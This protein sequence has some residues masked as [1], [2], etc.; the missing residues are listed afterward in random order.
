MTSNKLKYHIRRNH[1]PVEHE[2]H[3][4]LV[5]KKDCKTQRLLINH[6]KN[7]INF[8]C[9]FCEKIISAASY[10][11]HVRHHTTANNGKRSGGSNNKEVPSKKQKSKSSPA[12]KKGDS[13]EKVD[14]KTKITPKKDTKTRAK[15]TVTFFFFR[16][17]FLERRFLRF[18]F[19]LLF[20]KS[21]RYP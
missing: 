17:A 5:C 21:A 1:L 16:N 13:G 14:T 10:E 2:A 8:D 4:C 20:R 11:P 12:T 3:I 9:P 15:Q 7:H 18:I 6:Q 19:C